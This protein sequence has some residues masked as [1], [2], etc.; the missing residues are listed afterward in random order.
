MKRTLFT[1]VC[2]SIQHS[3]VVSADEDDA[4]LEIHLSPL[5]FWRRF[6]NAASYLLGRRSQWGDFEEII[7][8]PEMAL[9]LGDR[10][11]GWAQDESQ[12]FQP[13]DVF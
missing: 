1:C 5:P 3:F 4:F 11:I 12:I 10:L 13:N 2:G 7:L 9:D 6:R 8:T